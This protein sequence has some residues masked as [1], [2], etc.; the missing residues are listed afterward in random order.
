MSQRIKISP[1]TRLEGHGTIDI[2]LDDDGNVADAYFQVVELRGFEKFCEGRPVEELIRIMPKICGVCPG[3]HHMASAKAA[4]AVYGVEIPPAARKL[5]E[6][7]YNAHI[8]HSHM[9]HFFALAAPD[10]VPGADADPSKRNLL[11]LID[12]VGRDVGLDV[13]T[14]RGFAQRIQGTIA[15]HPI[16]PVAA[17]PGGMAHPLSERERAEVAEMGDSLVGFALRAIALFRER[18]LDRDDLVESISGDT[19][20]HRTHYAGLVDPHGKVNF[21]DGRVRVI[22]PEGA[23]LA[24]FDPA[25]YLDH[26]AER[27][28][29]WS[30]LKFPYL[31]AVGWRG[32]TDGGDSG[33]F[34]VNALARLN[35]ADGMATPL[36]Q[37]AYEEFF[38]FFG[39]RPVHHTLAFNWA[40][41]VEL[42]YAC[43]EVQRLASDPEITSTEI[44]ALP[45]GRPR[46]GVGV[47]EAARGTLYHHYVTDAEGM[48]KNVNLIVATVQNNAGMCMSVKR[49]AQAFIRGGEITDGILD[50]VEMAFRADDPCLACATHT[51]PGRMPLRLRVHR[52]DGS[53]ETVGR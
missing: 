22:D 31:K 37:Q 46:E 30:Y 41:L 35:V 52:T 16:H 42:L 1:I 40:R 12:E 4:D 6:L 32:V 27:V 13:L 50:R 29:P 24:L 21:Y 36:A 7:F 10:F 43:E 26:I 48:V 8:A 15:G 18:V 19:Y 44:R 11:G 34:R 17:V 45:T 47:V 9:L 38:S 5:R 28:E 20:L 14:H 2:L 53:I 3:A 33:V 49:A 25:D 23:Q 39:T 51:L